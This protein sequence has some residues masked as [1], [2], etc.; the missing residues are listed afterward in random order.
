MMTAKRAWC[1]CRPCGGERRRS[2]DL[3]TIAETPRRHCLPGRTVWAV[4]VVMKMKMMSSWCY[5][6]LM[7]EANRLKHTMNEEYLCR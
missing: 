4:V 1:Y 5:Y 7:V 2:D 6:N 3:M